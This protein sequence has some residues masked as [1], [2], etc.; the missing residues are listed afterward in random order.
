MQTK[1]FFIPALILLLH[2][3]SQAQ[4]VKS[5]DVT[6][7]FFSEAP[8]EDIQA[9]SKRAVSA[10]DTETGA[11]Y[12]KV[13]IQTF[14]FEKSLMQEHFN[15]NYLES[16]KYP[17]AEFKGKIKEKI[18]LS[19]AGIYPVTVQGEMTIHNVTRNYQ[20]EGKL[21]ITG[22]Q[23]KAQAVFPVK[24]ADHHIKIPTIVIKHIAEVVQVTVSA[25]YDNSNQEHQE[26]LNAT[27]SNK[28]AE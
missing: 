14:Q 7:S 25:S 4:V 21:Q 18:D 8:I 11:I 16:D 12:F 24:L 27:N 3:T 2:F 28:T 23:I 13:P 15:E 9:E 1:L 5:K 26:S 10:L 22:E 6:I 17:Y 19:K 20:V